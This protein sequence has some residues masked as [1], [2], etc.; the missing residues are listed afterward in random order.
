MTPLVGLVDW[1]LPATGPA[2]VTLAARAGADGVQ[3]DLGGPGRAD[4]IDGPGRLA[5]VRAASSAHGVPVLAVSAN[6]LNDIGLTAPDGSADGARV[7]GVLARLLDAAEALGAGLVLVPSFRRSAIDGPAALHRTAEVL[8]R[9]AAEAA[10]RG[11]LLAGENVLPPAAAVDLV[12]RVGSPAFRLLLDTYNPREA[13]LDTTELVAA[14]APFLADQIHLKDGPA[15][16]G[17]TPLLGDGDGA[18]DTTLDAVRR[19]RVHPYAVVLENDHRTTD[20]R[21]LAED[22]RRARRHAAALAPAATTATA[23]DPARTPPARATERT[24]T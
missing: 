11:L 4:P 15:G 3:V 14:T 2:A 23:D 16:P 13:G 24:S 7:R 22:L 21:L 18:L 1:R 9:A 12:T 6:T 20:P 8:S 17:G 5:A 10:A 19:H